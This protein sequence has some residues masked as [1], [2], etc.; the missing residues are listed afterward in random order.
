MR[1]LLRIALAALLASIALADCTAQRDGSVPQGQGDPSSVGPSSQPPATT[2]T[3]PKTPTRPPFVP[4][5]LTVVM[6]GDMLLH[7]GL[8]A[9]ARIDA[10]RTGRGVMDYRPI[11]ADMRPVVSSADLAIC[12]METPLAPKAGP[13]TAYPVFS[14]PPQIVAALKWEGYDACTTIS[15]HSLDDGFDGIVRTLDDFHRAGIATAGTVDH[16]RDAGKPLLLHANGVTVALIAATYGTNGFPL[17]AAEPWSVPII[18]PAAIKREARL[19][20]HEGAD[21]VM[22][23][24]HWGTEYV[25]APTAYQI[26]VAQSLT[27]SPNINFVYGEHAHVVQPYA[28]VNGTWV[29]YG[30]GNAVAQQDTAIVGVYDGNTVRVTFTERHDGTF[31]VSKLQYIPTMITQFDGVHPMRWLNVPQDIDKPA[32]AS[33][34]PALEATQQRVAGYV[35]SL[36]AFNHGVVEG[37]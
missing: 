25:H 4:R 1:G 29:V 37:K 36:G 17:P 13:F 9:S 22:V 23:G 3:T 7:E 30:M 10:E 32:Y 33:L 15:N 35:G 34:R 19:A 8:W 28:K 6:N 31:T 18:D 24:L 26:D 12:H 20:K 2:P 27:K 21:I 14:V 5:Q 16:K 11:L